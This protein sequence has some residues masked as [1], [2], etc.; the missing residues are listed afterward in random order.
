MKKSYLFATLILSSVLVACGPQKNE[1]DNSGTES[2][3]AEVTETSES[4][5]LD[6]IAA[7]GDIE[8]DEGLF[9]V[10]MTIP[11]DL[12]G[13][14][15]QEDLDKIKE[16]NGYKSVTLN[17]DGS[18]TYVMTKKQHSELMEQTKQA[19]DEGLNEIVTSED[20]P[21]I[22]AIEANKD[23]TNFK[24]TTKTDEISLA[25]SFTTLAF[26]MYG[27][28]YN[29]YNGT[30]VDNIEIEWINESTGEVYNTSNSKDMGNE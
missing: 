1:V 14:T 11:Q 13:E 20:Y 21:N 2:T 8:V 12:I 22:V 15:T 30:S 3:E 17:S 6:T 29:I 23:Y 9:N 27:G 7:V 10:E 16:E 4:S 24:V 28:M 26:Y 25:E 18:V 5:D 19:I